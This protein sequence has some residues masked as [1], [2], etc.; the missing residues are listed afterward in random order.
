MPQIV[1][2]FND[3]TVTY[4]VKLDTIN[5]FIRLYFNEFASMW[6]LDLLDNNSS[7]IALGLA[8]VPNV[9]ILR[10]SR[11]LT[12]TIGQLRI[13]TTNTGNDT[14]TSLGD[15]AILFYFLP[16]EF[17]TLFPNYNNPD[18]RAQQ[19]IFDDLFTVFEPP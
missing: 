11:E 16:G 9:N 18:V 5:Y 7:P 14:T 17:E 3:G 8:L 6:F 19:F 10:Y 15:D 4:T 1:P 2:T 12:Q 13:S